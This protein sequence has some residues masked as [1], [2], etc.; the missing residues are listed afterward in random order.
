MRQTLGRE[1]LGTRLTV[2]LVSS[3]LPA[4]IPLV[5][6][7][8]LVS[9]LPATIPLVS[10]SMLSYPSYLPFWDDGIAGVFVILV[11]TLYLCLLTMNDGAM[12]AISM[13]KEGGWCTWTDASYQHSDVMQNYWQVWSQACAVSL[14]SLEGL[15]GLSVKVLL[16]IKELRLNFNCWKH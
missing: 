6:S 14:L 3:L 8:T 13:R 11:W 1:G 10:G 7:S 16:C 12:E 4:T 9:S 15:S 5:S 2:P